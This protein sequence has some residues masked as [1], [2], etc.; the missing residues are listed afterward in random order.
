MI[1]NPPQMNNIGS[2]FVL[3]GTD[4]TGKTTQIKLLERRLL[5][6][7]Y[8][9]KIAD[10]PQYNTKSAGLV[11]EYLSGKYGE[12]N[13]VN[14][15][16][17][18]IFYAVDRFDASF[19]IKKWIKDGFV[20]LANRYVTANLAHQGSKLATPL[21]RK[22]FFDWVE[23]LEYKILRI[24]RPDKTIILRMPAQ[25]AQTLSN[26]RQRVDWTGKVRDIHEENLNHLSASE[27]V[28]LELNETRN[29]FSLINCYE[30]NSLLDINTINNQIWHEIR[31]YLPK[32]D[33]YLPEIS[34]TFYS[35]NFLKSNVGASLKHDVV[36]SRDLSLPTDPNKP[37]VIKTTPDKP[38]Y[39]IDIVA[40]RDYNIINGES[41]T[42]KPGYRTLLPEK[43]LGYVLTPK[44]L[45]DHNI[46]TQTQILHPGTDSEL[47]LRI[48]NN[49]HEPFKITPGQIVAQIVFHKLEP[50]EM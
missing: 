36:T 8:K 12:L 30:N 6:A 25:V 1:N 13:N 24:P 49:N 16:T 32:N 17:A 5:K 2:F 28:F 18:S 4:G 19:K 27:K 37:R 45:L 14:P 20:V 7:G 22:A 38:K 11:E 3:D 34:G 41:I 39:T 43:Y 15:Y 9:V 21:E 40:D 42:I 23:N 33:Y 29:N 31:E 35:P 50:I 47:V 10:F 48:K 26:K 44:N 46:K